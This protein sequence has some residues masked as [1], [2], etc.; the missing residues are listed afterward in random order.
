MFDSLRQAFREAAE[1]FRKE[2]NRDAVP[3]AADRLLRAMEKE[4]V[5]SR[6]QL[7]ELADLLERTR[8]EAAQ[9]EKEVR[10]CLRREKMARD[11]GD[12]E[13]AQI[14][15]DF[16]AKH[17]RRKDV[18]DEKASVLERELADR[19]A[20]FG[21]MTEQ[22]KEARVRRE[23]LS[24]SAGRTGARERIR[25]ADD[26]FARMDEMAE[27][28]EDFDARAGAAQEM[29]ELD[30]DPPPIRDDVDTRLEELKKR[31]GR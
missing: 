28:I 17:L 9:E 14:A 16:A 7:E 8:Q 22:F 13:T 3:E 21:E 5:D 26:L 30:A 20:E 29:S 10:T 1:N 4:M 6:V 15:S 2:L 23:A 19:K 27:R 24:A 18:L 25:D 11:I 31:M 12:E